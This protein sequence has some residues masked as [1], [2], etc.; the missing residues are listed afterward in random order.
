MPSLIEIGQGVLEEKTF[1]KFRQ[2][3]FA[4]SLLCSLRNG[5]AH[6]LN[7]F[8]FPSPKGALC[9]VGL[10]LAQWFWRRRFLNFVNVHVFSLFRNYLPL[11]KAVTLH[12]NKRQSSLAKFVQCFI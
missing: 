6:H 10:K 5:G 1:F 3:V 4:I 7:K 11:V 9:K 8:K 2:C 12:L